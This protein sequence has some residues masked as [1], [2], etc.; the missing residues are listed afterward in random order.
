MQRQAHLL[1]IVATGNASCSFSSLL[2]GREEE[3]DKYANNGDHNQKFNESEA[4]RLR[5]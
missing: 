2:N 1:E 5:R 4:S 3:A